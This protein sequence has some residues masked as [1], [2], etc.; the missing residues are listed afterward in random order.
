MEVVANGPLRLVGESG[1]RLGRG[2]EVEQK[3]EPF[4]QS[5]SGAQNFLLVIYR[6]GRIQSDAKH[7]RTFKEHRDAQILDVR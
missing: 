1:F 7:A 6:D 2:L 4:T 5:V 3:S